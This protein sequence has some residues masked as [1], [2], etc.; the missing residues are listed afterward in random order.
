M[1]KHVWFWQNG[2]GFVDNDQK[3]AK[4]VS[5]I[6]KAIGKWSRADVG[7][8]KMSLN[9]FDRF[10]FNYEGEVWKIWAR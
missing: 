8:N 7:G 2:D 10:R 4:I 5:A 3:L 9:T 6:E 1:E